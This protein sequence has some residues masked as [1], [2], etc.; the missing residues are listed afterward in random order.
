MTL[1]YCN[2]SET[3][4]PRREGVAEKCISHAGGYEKCTAVFEM[5]KRLQAETK[6]DI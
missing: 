6:E 4:L 2:V 5:K 3:R 1:N